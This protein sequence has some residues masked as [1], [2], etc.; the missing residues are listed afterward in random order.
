MSAR[1]DPVWEASYAAG[2]SQLYPWDAVVSF[3]FRYAPRERPRENVRILEVG[4]G[5]GS[6]LWFAA[7]EGFAV[8]GIDGSPSA[9]AH[10]RE[11]FAR[12]GLTG[13]FRVATFDNLPFDDDGS[14][15][16][17]LDRAALSCVSHAAGRAGVAE[18]ARV[19]RSGGFFFFNPY[20]DRHSSAAAGTP[21]A[22]GLVENIARGSLVGAGGISFYGR[23]DVERALP[24][25]WRIR[26][27]EHME[28]SDLIDG[29]NLVHAEWRVVAEKEARAHVTLRP[30]HAQDAGKVFSWRN[31]HFVA[32][33]STSGQL[34]E[35]CDHE[36]WFANSL[37]SPD[38]L[39]LI[40][41][42]DG[43]DA[44]VVRFDWTDNG[45]AVISIYLDESKT[46]RGAGIA[47]IRDGGSRVREVWPA[48]R[49]EAYVR[50]DNALGHKA[51]A[52]AGYT[53]IESAGCPSEHT[54]YTLD[55]G[56]DD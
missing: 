54:A 9:I 16:L 1:V 38:R 8:C 44:G 20:S 31:T 43:E 6:N 10:A 2:H 17:A 48:V 28:R 42:I 26:S 46:G 11:R 37:A 33:R 39:L 3:V 50:N 22:D 23:D 29:N 27:L 5:T 13:D 36:T 15:D 7:R 32:S 55:S 40:V 35:H 21:G 24:A 4:C 14:F 12:D 51:F 18:V 53:R 19:L 41:C 34:V 52:K 49:I 45:T 30:A 56:R 47:A 25:P